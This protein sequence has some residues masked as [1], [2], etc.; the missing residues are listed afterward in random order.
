MKE[1][2]PYLTFSGNCREAMNFYKDC[3]GGEL[4]LQTI[5]ESPLAE[6]MPDKMKT[7][8]LHASLTNESITLLGSDMVPDPGLNR[9]NNVSLSLTCD[10]ESDIRLCYEKL[11]SGGSATHPVEQTFFGALLG[12]LTDKFGIHWLLFYEGK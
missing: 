12:G 4:F 5:G 11:S 9:G 3:L 1:L 8:I 2:R 10:S 7:C 6:K